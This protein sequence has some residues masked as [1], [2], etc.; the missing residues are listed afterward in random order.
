MQHYKEKLMKNKNPILLLY[1]GIAL[2]LVLFFLAEY[3]KL[4]LLP[5]HTGTMYVSALLGPAAGILATAVTFL[6]ISLFFYGQEFFWFVLPGIILSFL[7]G[8]QCKKDARITNWLVTA[9][10][11][12]LLDLFFYILIV[13]W[14]HNS[15]PYDYRGQRI[16]MYFY[17]KGTDEIISVCLAGIPIVLLS[18]IQAV[19]TAFLGIL[20]TPKHWITVPTEE[21]PSEQKGL[22]CQNQKN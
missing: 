8:E 21:L 22:Q 4:P 12:I 18:G 13:L 9:G 6:F 11:V 3:F 15:I 10:E 1:I 7:V 20:C 16:F 5:Y 19:A 2:N 14:K 17:E